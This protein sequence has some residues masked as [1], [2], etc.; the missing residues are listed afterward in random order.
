[1]KFFILRSIILLLLLLQGFTPLLHAH[2]LGYGVENGL[3]VDGIILQIEKI[4]QISS[5]EN[6]YQSNI[7]ISMSGAVQQKNQLLTDLPQ[8]KGLN[9]KQLVKKAVI[10]KQI[11]FFSPVSTASSIVELSSIAPRAPPFN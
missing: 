7:A 10:S 9:Y 1:M 4:P 3:H 6:T 11:N 2:V 8:L 5:F